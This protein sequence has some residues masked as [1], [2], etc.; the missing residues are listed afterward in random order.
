MANR[1]I[2][3]PKHCPLSWWNM[4]ND[5]PTD[6]RNKIFS[7]KPKT[8]CKI[9]NVLVNLQYRWTNK[10]RQFSKQWNKLVR[11]WF[12]CADLYIWICPK[13]MIILRK[14]P[15]HIHCIYF[16]LRV[17]SSIYET[18]SN[19]IW[20]GSRV[21]CLDSD[22]QQCFT[23]HP[24]M[25]YIQCAKK[26]HKWCS[27]SEAPL[28]PHPT[29]HISGHQRK[30]L[31]KTESCGGGATV[32]I[33]RGLS[34]PTSQD[35]PVLKTEKPFSAKYLEALNNW[36]ICFCSFWYIYHNNSREKNKDIFLKKNTNIWDLVL[37]WGV[38][39]ISTPQ[40]FSDKNL[41]YFDVKESCFHIHFRVLNSKGWGVLFEISLKKSTLKTLK[42]F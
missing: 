9:P 28:A 34:V 37:N 2:I 40:N 17:I 18:V 3:K 31:L 19:V 15:S 42:C 7:T 16:H 13:G 26:C 41:T 14:M 1:D 38:E 10:C 39:C 20:A 21:L 33:W 36:I 35:V 8:G 23:I 4:Q 6:L 12:Q 29:P 30:L 11:F 27:W 32:I 25:S 22:C 24:T 5:Q